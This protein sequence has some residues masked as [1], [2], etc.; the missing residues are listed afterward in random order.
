MRGQ[1]EGPVI[2]QGTLRDTNFHECAAVTAGFRLPL[3]GAW[4]KTTL[5]RQGLVKQIGPREAGGLPVGL[6]VRPTALGSGGSWAHLLLLVC[7]R[8]I[9]LEGTDAPRV[10]YNPKT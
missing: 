7:R 9:H 6:I 10:F 3:G 1:G 4:Q 2:C 8:L 5:V